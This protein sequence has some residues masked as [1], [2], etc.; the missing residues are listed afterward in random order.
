MI[1]TTTSTSNLSHIYTTV[2]NVAYAA[3]VVTGP[4]FS[5]I[6]ISNGMSTPNMHCKDVVI[7]GKP[8]SSILEKMQQRLAILENPDPKKLE[9]YAA[10][11]KAYDHYVMLEKLINLEEN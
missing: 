5:N 9:K 8:L 6:N 4:T 1:Y 10:L 7:D 11:K 2:D 3:P